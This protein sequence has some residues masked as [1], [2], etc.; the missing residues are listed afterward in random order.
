MGSREGLGRL[1]RKKSKRDWYGRRTC[2]IVKEGGAGE[3]G[4]VERTARLNS[5]SNLAKIRIRFTKEYLINKVAVSFLRFKIFCV[6]L[7]LIVERNA[8][9]IVQKRNCVLRIA[10]LFY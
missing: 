2:E 1:G 5:S 3:I 8:L 7:A 4:K 9:S 6:N 10:L